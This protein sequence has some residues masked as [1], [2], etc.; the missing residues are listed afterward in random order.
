M[1]CVKPCRWLRSTQFSNTFRA[2][3]EPEFSIELPNDI[4]AIEPAVLYVVQ[5]LAAATGLSTVQ[6]IRVGAALSSALF[7]AMC[8]GNLEIKEEDPV[9]S[10]MFTED[11]RNNDEVRDR[12][13]VHPYRDRKVQLRVSV[14]TVDTRFSY[15]MM[16]R[17]LDPLDPSTGDCGVV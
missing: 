3:R 6:R 17:P 2:F 12:A 11:S 5:T 7:N 14:S 8:Y 9:V 1:L 16:P 13:A 15:H 4:A 10:R